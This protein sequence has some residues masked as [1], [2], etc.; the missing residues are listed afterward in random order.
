MRVFFRLS[1]LALVFCCLAACQSGGDNTLTIKTTEGDV[2]VQLF[3]ETPLHKENF[4]KL[5]REG[6][7]EGTLFHRVIPNFMIQGGD[8]QS[9]GA[10]AGQPLG[11]GGPGY[12]VDAEIGQP[13][14]RGALA[15]ARTGNPQKRSS[16]SQFY[17]V[18][19]QPQSDATLD[20]YERMKNIKYNDAQRAAYKT[21]GGRPDLDQEYT[22]FGMVVSGMDVVDRI[23]GAATG[24]GDRPVKD[25]MIEKVIVN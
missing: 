6:F 10:P 24:P 25:V 20:Q 13:H 21:E 1:L 2:V 12:L 15:A 5:A 22:V 23:G 17:I 19:G 14:L 4:L 9:V 18:T 16:G 3:D 7:Y 8:P 11:S